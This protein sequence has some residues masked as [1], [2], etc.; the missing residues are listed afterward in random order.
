MVNELREPSVLR[1]DSPEYER[2]GD[3]IRQLYDLCGPE[4]LDIFP[5]KDKR[6]ELFRTDGIVCERPPMDPCT[7]IAKQYFGRMREAMMPPA[8]PLHEN[9]ERRPRILG[10]LIRT[11]S[12]HLTMEA[13]KNASAKDLPPDLDERIEAEVT[14]F[15]GFCA[16]PEDCLLEV[17]PH[18]FNVSSLKKALRN[19][20]FLEERPRIREFYARIASV[21]RHNDGHL[22]GIADVLGQQH[23]QELFAG[24]LANVGEMNEG[25]LRRYF[26][27]NV[28]YMAAA[29]LRLRQDQKYGAFIGICKSLDPVTMMKIPRLLEDYIRILMASQKDE[30]LLKILCTKGLNA[31]SFTT[32]RELVQ[33]ACVYICDKIF[34]E[35][36]FQAVCNVIEKALGDKSRWWDNADLRELYEVSQEQ[37]TKP[38]EV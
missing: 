25:A 17:F 27:N 5:S 18:L 7:S 36:A 14:A 2:H 10:A 19:E 16:D 24:Y 35:G 37:L 34:Q 28:P 23:R 26:A 15:F 21:F 22:G 12:L 30:E 38:E 13:E 1:Y 31:N 33:K 3:K 4:D 32:R 6:P 9:A 8:N 29:L 11:L 20:M